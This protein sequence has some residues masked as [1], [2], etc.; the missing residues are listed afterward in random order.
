MF[1]I[2][3]EGENIKN[4]FNFY[5]LSD[6]SSFGFVFRYGKKLPLTNFGSKLFWFRYQKAYGKWVIGK[7]RV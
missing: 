2:R 6:Q 4:G 7:D 3:K 5:P 1:C